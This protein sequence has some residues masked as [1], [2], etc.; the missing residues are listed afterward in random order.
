MNKPVRYLLQAINLGLF[1]LLIAAFSSGPAV[2]QLEAD[3]AVVT[4][5]FGHAGQPVRECRART[6]EELAALAPNMRAPMDCPRERSVIKV[7]L[8]MDGE[9]VFNLDAHPPGAFKDQGVDVYHSIIV[10]AGKHR[11]TVRLNDSA[12]IEG[13]NHT[14]EYEADLAPAQLLFIDF[15]AGMGGFIF[16]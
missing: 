13:Y 15:N 1:M 6:P 5:A 14:G 12:L 11:F 16:N 7:L 4:L 10:P 9:E 2:K 3:E 8:E